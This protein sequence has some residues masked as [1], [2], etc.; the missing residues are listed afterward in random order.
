ME[1]ATRRRLEANQAR[2]KGDLMDCNRVAP[3]QEQHQHQ[4]Q[5]QNQVE[6]PSYAET[7]YDYEGYDGPWNVNQTNYGGGLSPFNQEYQPQDIDAFGKGKGKGKGGKPGMAGNQDSRW[8]YVCGKQGHIS[9]DCRSAKAA[10]L[11]V[12]GIIG[13]PEGGPWRPKGKG[14]S[15]G[16]GKYG[17]KGKG[18]NEVEWGHEEPEGEAA[19]DIQA[20]G[21]WISNSQH[22]IR[23]HISKTSNIHVIQR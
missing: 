12:K 1:F 16:K 18:L 5:H 7:Q 15:K 13:G 14:K 21:G 23:R 10:E 3:E 20:M 6:Y 22:C 4:H 2:L 8:C 19:G 11:R 9:R 17:G